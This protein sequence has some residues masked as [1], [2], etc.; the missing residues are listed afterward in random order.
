MTGGYITEAYGLTE[1]SPGACA[2]PLGA[3]WNGTIGLPFPSTDVSIRDDGFNELPVW[4]GE[5]D[6]STSVRARS[7]CAARRS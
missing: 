7:A 4:T 3:P 1:T 6:I 2:N 5:G